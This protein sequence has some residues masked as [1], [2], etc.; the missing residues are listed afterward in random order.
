MG[1]V[2]GHTARQPSVKWKAH[3]TAGAHTGYPLCLGHFSYRSLNCLAPTHYLS[4]K[5]EFKCHF[6]RPGALLL[7]PQSKYSLPIPC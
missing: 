3:S 6:L 1:G 7:T 2:K 4:F 5:A